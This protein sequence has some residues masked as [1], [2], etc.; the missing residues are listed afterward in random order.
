[1]MVIAR[2]VSAIDTKN[3]QLVAI[4]LSGEAAKRI[5]TMAVR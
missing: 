4:I 5:N 2:S 3:R 1:M